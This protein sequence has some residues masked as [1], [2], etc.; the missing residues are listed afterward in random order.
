MMLFQNY[1]FG[2][3]GD[4]LQNWPNIAKER[5][6]F[7]ACFI[8]GKFYYAKAKLLDEHVDELGEVGYFQDHYTW[9]LL[10]SYNSWNLVILSN[11]KPI[12]AFQSSFSSY[13]S[14]AH[15]DV[16]RLEIENA[17]QTKEVY[18]YL[19]FGWQFH[20]EAKNYQGSLTTLN[21]SNFVICRYWHC[22]NPS[23]LMIKGFYF[24]LMNILMFHDYLTKHKI[25]N[26]STIL[27]WHILEMIKLCLWN[28]STTYVA[29]L[30]M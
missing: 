15:F 6:S 13:V 16:L 4:D 3:I 29:H 5:C 25:S 24:P 9:G 19:F 28:L 2:C 14:C 17:F 11:S 10:V 22:V 21:H 1:N 23:L 7:V 8:I 30:F 20:E 18:C 26:G 27:G 12:I